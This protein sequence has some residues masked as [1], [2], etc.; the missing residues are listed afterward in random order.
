ML[1]NRDG[2]GVGRNLILEKVSKSSLV[3]DFLLSMNI[4]VPNEDNLGFIAPLFCVQVPG[5]SCH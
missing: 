1:R 5:F 4:N 2:G 3:S